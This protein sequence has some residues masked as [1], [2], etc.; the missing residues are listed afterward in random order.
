M[1]SIDRMT[2]HKLE[3]IA[4]FTADPWD[5][6]MPVVRV[7]S[8][9]NLA[10]IDVLPGNHSNQIHF[11]VLEK[12]DALVIQRDFPRFDDYPELIQRGS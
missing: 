3:T 9:A 1:E 4:L 7:R 8:P 10:G 6:A 12:C 5:S 11:E 2:K